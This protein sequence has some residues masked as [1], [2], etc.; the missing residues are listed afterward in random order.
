MAK[1][2]S[3][4]I[5]K[6]IRAELD[7]LY[8]AG[9]GDVTLANLGRVSVDALLDN[10]AIRDSIKAKGH[11]TPESQREY[12]I[13]EIIAHQED[14]VT[15]DVG[16]KDKH[17]DYVLDASGKPVT[18]KEK[19]YGEL[20]PEDE[21]R[22]ALQSD[23]KIV[24][25][26]DLLDKD[27]SLSSKYG[28]RTDLARKEL[29]AKMRAA[30]AAAKS[31][32]DENGG[33]ADVD[34]SDDIGSS[35][36]DE[37]VK[38]A[39]RQAADADARKAK[40]AADV[41][42]L[43]ARQ[44]A[45]QAARDNLDE[46]FKLGVI[47]AEELQKGKATIAL[48][49]LLQDTNPTMKSL[50]DVASYM[51]K[52]KDGTVR[53]WYV[54][55]QFKKAQRRH[56]AISAGAVN[57]FNALTEDIQARI[58]GSAP[59][60]RNAGRPKGLFSG[61]RDR[62]NSRGSKQ[63]VQDD[64][65]GKTEKKSAVRAAGGTILKA[66]G[67][68]VTF[69]GVVAKNVFKNF[70]PLMWV[71]DTYKNIRE[72]L[73]QATDDNRKSENAK[74]PDVVAAQYSDMV[75]PKGESDKL[76]PRMLAMIMVASRA[77]VE[78]MLEDPAFVQRMAA[79]ARQEQPEEQPAAKTEA[80]KPGEQPAA[81]AEAEKPGEQPAAKTEAEKSGEQPA[82]KTEAE[83]PGEQ[84]AAKTAE[85]KPA[86]QPGAKTEAEKP[87]E[88]PAAKTDAGKPE[89]QP[90]RTSYPTGADVA[91]DILAGNTHT[92]TS[93]P[94]SDGSGQ[95][96]KDVTAKERDPEYLPLES[97]D[98]DGESD[99]SYLFEGNG[100]EPDEEEEDR[101][102]PAVKNEKPSA[103]RR[104]EPAEKDGHGGQTFPAGDRKEEPAGGKPEEQ[105]APAEQHGAEDAVGAAAAATAAKTGDTIGPMFGRMRAAGAASDK[106]A[107][108]DAEKEGGEDSLA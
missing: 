41:A 67:A 19:L 49:G 83:K 61:F 28:Y 52:T 3:I 106:K 14:I 20:L 29:S 108:E 99:T 11:D 92:E 48:H 42:E 1:K 30:G 27:G 94:A 53:T 78:A 51:S 12:V 5:S 8:Q 66:A 58:G 79:T 56:A 69:S 86:E 95:E 7:D 10:A 76:D 17:G 22:A 77:A 104:E 24:I 85:E 47:S 40:A 44:L 88:Q 75:N 36:E 90:G 71:K 102:K 64:G 91:A 98:A 34:Y 43:N 103:E 9:C 81:K 96:E 37:A 82:A 32:D 74:D 73:K 80:E 68:A 31:A 60:S 57:E 105:A 65:A 45:R 4:D 100:D 16:Q 87:G 6:R 93:A 2:A 13:S 35:E 84:P 15:A 46:L 62:V 101:D 70:H 54:G 97:Y 33:P 39:R 21:L 25:P 89:E 38:S 26:E 59:P 55:R 50:S 72:D 63:A 107:K 23:T 18:K